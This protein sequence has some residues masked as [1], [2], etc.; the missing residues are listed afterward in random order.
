MNYNGSAA[1][2]IRGAT[3]CNLQVATT[4][5]ATAT[6]S[7]TVLTIVNN[8][9][10][11]VSGGIAAHTGVVNLTVSGTTS[12]AGTM[13]FTTAATGTKQ[14]NDVTVNSGGVWNNAINSDITIN[15]NIQQDGTF[16]SGTGLYTLAGATK[17][18]SGISALSISNPT[19]SG[20]YTNNYTIA[21]GCTLSV[22]LPGPITY[23]LAG[24]GSLTQATNAIL[25]VGGDFTMTGAFD[26]TTNTP[27][28]VCYISSVSAT[29][30]VKATAY[31]HFIVNKSLNNAN[32]A[33]SITVNGNLTIT[34][35]RLNANGANTITLYGNWSNSATF[36]YSTGTVIFTGTATPQTISG[37]TTFYNLTINKA[38]NN[39]TLNSNITVANAGTLT[40]TKGNIVTGTNYVIIAAGG[41]VS[42]AAQGTGWVQGY[43]QKNIAL[44]GPVLRD[45]EVGGASVYAPVNMTFAS[46]TTAGNFIVKN[47]DGDHSQLA[48]SNIYIDSSLN[49][50][51]R[52]TN[53]SVT[54]TTF[55]AVFNF[56]NSDLDAGPPAVDPTSTG[57]T[58]KRFDGFDW[59]SIGIGAK[60]A[61]STQI[62]GE[63]ASAYA[64]GYRELAFGKSLKTT[65][66]YTRVTGAANWNTASTWIRY[67]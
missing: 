28:T 22:I 4:L 27:N 54:F 32:L 20:S 26:A 55:D 13:N 18:I 31:H 17:T 44:G 51:W 30:V 45:F 63:P 60:T 53:S 29:Q 16:T 23:A 15:G 58:G 65:D 25:Y 19:I 67:M 24:G 11:V 52:L 36:T 66:I 59:V 64:S 40:F 61:T 33:G 57:F 47:Y 12:I 1:Q 46:V 42:G 62:T 14:F 21:N 37:A 5:G 38:S 6:F 50:Y 48:S 9:F 41:T 56:V 3:Y 8:N 10:T 7:N 2:T 49:R 34:S 39:V 43:L 35:G